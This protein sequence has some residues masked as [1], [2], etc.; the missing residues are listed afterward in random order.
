[1]ATRAPF[2]SVLI[3]T[4]NYGG[5]IEEA[6][7]SVLGQTFPRTDTEII[8]VDDGSTDDTRERVQRYGDAIR[9]IHQENG[10]QA[11]AFNLGLRHARGEFVAFLDADDRWHPDKLAT[12]AAG[13]AE[14][15]EVDT[16]L[17]Y[18]DVIDETG[19]T[20]G[21]IP[22]EMVE[23]IVFEPRPLESVLAGRL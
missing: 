4:Y 19:R 11:S 23:P 9:Y 21:V 3:A 5:F 6:L 16:V 17:H 20:I 7:D 1:M 10:G 8:V 14:T 18:L 15:P 13:F 22:D 2:A 12:V